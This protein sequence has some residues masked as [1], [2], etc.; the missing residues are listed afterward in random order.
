MQHSRRVV[1]LVLPALLAAVSLIGA[2][3]AL[4]AAAAAN[5]IVAENQQPG[6]FAW[7]WGTRI[8]DDGTGQIK[9]YASAT[10]VVQ[11][12]QIGFYV[13]VN[14]A[15][16]YTIDFYRIGWYGGLGGRLRLHA[17]PLQGE[18]QATCV[19]DA[20]TGLNACDWT[21]S[22]GLTVPS[23]WTTGLYL[24]KLINANGYESYMSFVVRDDRPAAYLYQQSVNT[25]QAYNNYPDDGRTGKSLYTY[26]SYG[27]NTVSGE[28][29]AVKVSFD[30]PYAGYG[31]GQFDDF[32]TIRWLERMGY[33]VTYSTD[34]DTHER[35]GAVASHRA[36]ISAG[37][38]EYWSKAMFDSVEA[39]RDAGTSLAFL[40]AN[41][42]FW[43]VRFEPSTA[44]IADRV[45]VCYRS[46][47]LD[48]ELGPTTTVQWRQPPVNRAE[49]TLIG[50]QFTDDVD[51]GSNVGY[52]VTNSAHWAYAGTGFVDGD[53]VPGIVGYEMD[54]LWTQYPKANARA[55]ALLSDSPFTAKDGLQDHANSSLYVAPSGAIVFASGTMS[56]AWALDSFIHGL[57][58]TRIQR[59]TGNIFDAFVHGVPVTVTRL[60]VSA[61]ATATSGLAVSVT[62]T[63]ADAD[64]QPVTGYDG[65]VH[66]ATS[67]PAPGV[68]LP[69]DGPLTSGQQT[70]PVTLRTSGPQTLTVSDAAHGLS[71]TVSIDVAPRATRLVVTAPAAASAG[72]PIDVMVK[73][74]DDSGQVSSGYA[75]T[76]HFTSTDTSASVVLPADGTLTAGQGQFSVTLARAG[77][78][79][80]TVADRTDASISGG[81]PVDVVAGPASRFAVTTNASPTAGTS[82]AFAVAAVDQYGNPAITYAGT[83]HFASTDTSQGVVLPLDAPLDAGHASFS[84]TLIRAGAQTVSASDGSLQGSLAV[85][86]RAAAATRLVV[87]T[88]AGPVAGT[89]FAFT[90]TAQDQ[91]GNTDAG[92]ADRLHFTSS[93]TS[94]GV[95]LPADETLTNG[96][97]TLAA[98]LIRAGAQTITVAGTSPSPLRSTLNVTVAPAAAATVVFT[99]PSSVLPSQAFDVRVTFNDQYGNVATGYRGTVQFTTSDPSPLARV[100]ANYTFTAADAGAH[101]FSAT[102]WTPTSQT[103][104]V[105]DTTNAALGGTSARITV[106]IGL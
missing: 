16:S 31:F 84:A 80:I 19:P 66:F 5:P 70:F 94:T 6:T 95:A 39:A 105:R 59:M 100:P 36:Y 43:Q 97:A 101:T 48:P 92:Y 44:G 50:I 76:V 30:R 10:S 35:G 91:F 90:V 73:A 14:P 68:I 33:D 9:G 69:P 60:A 45:L 103:I 99:V 27:P 47:S 18:T 61:P 104:T 89:S 22:Y 93:D 25:T 88:A 46:A 38:D 4:P 52:V 49:Q 3:P 85:Q 63:A 106:G 17:G 29:R 8:S 96:S 55:S 40:G 1:T 75:G 77:A 58:D 72:S 57:G 86:V 67:D 83:V 42:A 51:P 15:Q 64:G 7:L 32:N 2:L 13:T 102:L 12:Q 41:A 65:T 34:L 87:T 56:W 53:T 20:T 54:K 74:V 98:T 24:A 28:T 78:Q 82:F 71:T 11:G 21:L 26:N 37:H 79:S 23:D 62:V 81:A